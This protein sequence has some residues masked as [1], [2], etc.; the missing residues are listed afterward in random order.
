MTFQACAEHYI[1]SHKAG[2]KNPKHAAQWPATLGTYVYPAFGQLPV[3]AVDT[4]L[5]MKVTG[6]ARTRRAGA[7]ISTSCSRRRARSAASSIMRRSPMTS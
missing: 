7:G 1:A 5:V 6:K 2:W 3:S 4:G